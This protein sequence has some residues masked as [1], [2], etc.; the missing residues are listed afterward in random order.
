MS[1]VKQSSG[2]FAV[3]GW[4]EMPA[5]NGHA[6][7]PQGAWWCWAM[8]GVVWYSGDLTLPSGERPLFYFIQFPQLWDFVSSS[9]VRIFQVV[10]VCDENLGCDG[11]CMEGLDGMESEDLYIFFPFACFKVFFS[12]YRLW[13]WSLLL[14]FLFLIHLPLRTWR[15]GT[16]FS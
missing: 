13:V 8:G 4:L 6:G 3:L 10:R 1:G 7:S 14:Y 2:E 9:S 15:A 16:D 5:W 12:D 11:I